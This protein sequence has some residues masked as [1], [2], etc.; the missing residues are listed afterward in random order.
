MNKARL[1]SKKNE[2]NEEEEE[3][4]EMEEEE[5]EE[6]VE[7][8]ENNSGEFDYSVLKSRR[9]LTSEQ[10]YLVKLASLDEE[11]QT[12]APNQR[13]E[14]R[15]HEASEKLKG[16]H[17]DLEEARNKAQEAARNFEKVRQ[18]RMDCFMN[19]FNHVA[20]KIDGIYKDL[21][22][23]QNA[24]MGGSAFLAVMDVENPF[25]GGIKFECMP[26]NKRFR[27]MES[28]SGG[29]KTV[30]ALALLF[31]IHSYR[32]S[33]FF[34]LDEVDAALDN[35]NVER[36]SN[37]IRMR[38]S[39]REDHDN[40]GA[41]QKQREDE[42]EGEDTDESLRRRFQCLVISLKDAFYCKAEALVGVYRDVQEDSSKCLTLDLSIYGK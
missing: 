24:P 4:E 42:E 38:S 26:P 7:D 23:R 28:L 31:A 39:I 1:R 27:A 16:T 17:Q 40:E 13:A 34:V 6:A 25:T 2:K 29:E 9:D 3:D 22:K 36:V 21:T 5:E 35:D 37:Y 11:L 14:T 32:P 12:L 20:T 33:P 10:E 18:E 41:E 30:A 15:F 19:M 8:V